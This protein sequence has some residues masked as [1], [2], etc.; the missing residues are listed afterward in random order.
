MR[1]REYFG[2]YL[3]DDNRQNRPI[4]LSLT[5]FNLFVSLALRRQLGPWVLFH[6]GIGPLM[7]PGHSVQTK[8]EKLNLP[9]TCSSLKI[10][11]IWFHRKISSR[12]EK[13]SIQIV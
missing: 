5:F 13:I 1:E 11:H 8:K 3:A 6:D 10:N 9:V 4:G 7:L 12:D 2:G